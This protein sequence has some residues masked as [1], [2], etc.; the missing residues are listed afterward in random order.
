ME[1]LFVQ[2]QNKKRAYRLQALKMNGYNTVLKLS[3]RQIPNT[4]D[5]FLSLSYYALLLEHGLN[6]Q[7]IL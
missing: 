3:A 6:T 2:G 7:T 4:L 1:P 5:S